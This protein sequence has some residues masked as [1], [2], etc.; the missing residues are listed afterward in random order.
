[1][2]M[3]KQVT[4]QLRNWL[5]LFF[6]SVEKKKILYK[7]KKKYFECPMFPLMLMLAWSNFDK[8]SQ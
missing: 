1:M 5:K 3:K 4:V 7:H 6:V 2:N 8:Q